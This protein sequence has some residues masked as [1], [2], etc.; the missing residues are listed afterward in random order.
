MDTSLFIM[1]EL[2]IESSPSPIDH[3]FA[4]TCLI[5]FIFAMQEYLYFE[6]SNGFRAIVQ[7]QLIIT[8]RQLLIF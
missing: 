6:L 3:H 4:D 8:L 2:M 7:N 5:K 1:R